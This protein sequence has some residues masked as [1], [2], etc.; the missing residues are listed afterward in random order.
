MPG[1]DQ[2]TGGAVAPEQVIPVVEAVLEFN[3]NNRQA[4]LWA[5]LL[6]YANGAAIEDWGNDP[7]GRPL[8]AQ[9]WSVVADWLTSFGEQRGYRLT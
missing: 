9:P 4:D 6:N 1:A 7:L 5:S 3:V 2:V 8:A